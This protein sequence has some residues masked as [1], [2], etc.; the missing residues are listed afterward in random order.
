MA[1]KKSG[2]K[3]A[4]LPQY[5]KHLDILGHRFKIEYS[6]EA[7][8]G[9]LAGACDGHGRKIYV[10]LAPDWQLTLF[11]EMVHAVLF[12]TGHSFRMSESEEE[13]LVRALEHGLGPIFFP[14]S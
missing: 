13:A 10:W 9:N 7:I 8:N 3:K 12:L 6:N 11:H 4:D 5:P 14:E 2:S 1:K